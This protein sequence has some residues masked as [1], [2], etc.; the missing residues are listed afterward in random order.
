LVSWLVV[1]QLEAESDGLGAQEVRKRR[2]PG[3]GTL[4]LEFH[5]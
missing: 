1:L 5:S 4:V 2:F 3:R